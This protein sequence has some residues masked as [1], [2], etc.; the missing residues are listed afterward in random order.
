MSEL[1][2]LRKQLQL[3]NGY[4]GCL[5]V[6]G[7]RDVLERNLEGT[8]FAGSQCGARSFDH[9]ASFPEDD[10][11]HVVGKLGGETEDGYRVRSGIMDFPGEG[12]HFLV[13]EVLGAAHGQ[14]CDFNVL[15]ILLLS[16]SHFGLSGLLEWGCFATL[17]WHEQEPKTQQNYDDGKGGKADG[18]RRKFGFRF[19]YGWIFESVLHGSLALRAIMRLTTY[20][21][22]VRERFG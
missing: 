22:A 12:G 18:E 15:G 4:R 17:E 8:A 2:F 6:P 10:L 14:I 1:L 21:Q 19:W 5:H 3:R 16:G 13:Q 7:N 20:G 9:P 11:M